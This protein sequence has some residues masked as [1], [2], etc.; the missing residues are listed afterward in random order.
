MKE[1]NKGYNE[2]WTFDY[3]DQGLFYCIKNV[4][5]GMKVPV[6]RFL[7]LSPQSTSL[8]DIYYLS[9]SIYDCC[10]TGLLSLFLQAYYICIAS[11]A[12]MD[13][14]ELTQSSEV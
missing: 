6:N 12:S 10:K 11:Q 1:A 7:E 14:A 4:Q 9:S 5:S 13:K 3:L 2:I 8:F